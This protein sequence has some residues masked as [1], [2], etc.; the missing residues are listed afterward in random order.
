MAAL[1]QGL[2]A[3]IIRNSGNDTAFTLWCMFCLIL[4]VIGD[5]LTLI[6]EA[7]DI[8]LFAFDCEWGFHRNP[9][10]TVNVVNEKATEVLTIRCK[11]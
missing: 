3:T 9:D 11:A 5:G 1:F 10:K 7:R 8:E 6:P 2:P 4:R